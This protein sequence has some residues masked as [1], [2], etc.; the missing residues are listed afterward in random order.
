MSIKMG[1]M[2][3]RLS[4]SI[5][6]TIQSFPEKSWAKEFELG[7]KINLN[8][9]EWIFDSYIKNPIMNKQI[10]EINNYIAKFQV[11]VNSICADY[12]MI[13]KL[14]NESE[15]NIKNNLEVLKELAINGKKI[16]A[17]IIE[18]PLVDSSSLK[19]E[20]NKKE[21]VTNL[22]KV[23]SEI[24]DLGLIITLETDLPP[25]EFLNLLEMF[26]KNTVYANY[27]TGN[28][29]SL[30]YNVNEE[31][32]IL[33]GKIKNIHLKDRILGG[34]TVP[35]GLGNTNFEEFF[36]TLKKSEYSGDLIIQ[37]ARIEEMKPEQNCIKYLN[38]IKEYLDKY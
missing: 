2:Q 37:A 25:K 32:K 13:N 23:I 21:L 19:T 8:S 26:E 35:L 7:Q 3:G 34:T 4:H 28:S 15:K 27:D 14:F 5:N 22:K 6:N 33:K 31:F 36:K 16:G 12:F 24:N 29:A 18:I 11:K 38:F 10:S 17:K 20:K 30:G 1:I 9:I